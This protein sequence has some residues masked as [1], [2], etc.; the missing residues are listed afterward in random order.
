[1]I[2]SL[3]IR[4]IRPNET[5][6]LL[7]FL[8]EAVFLQEGEKKPPRS[9]TRLPALYAYVRDFGTKKG[10]LCFC[11]EVDGRVAGAVWVRLMQGFGHVDEETPELAVALYAPFRGRGWGSALMTRMLRE[12]KARGC[13]KTSLSVHRENPALKLYRRLGYRTVKERDEDLILEYVF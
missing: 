13:T 1:M 2:M 6:L 3:I 4:P 5:I 10:D 7:D 8:Y 9:I 12:L 11:A